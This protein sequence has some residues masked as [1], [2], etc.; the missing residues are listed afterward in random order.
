M[1][2]GKSDGLSNIRWQE[3]WLPHTHPLFSLSVTFLSWFTHSG[4]GHVTS[5]TMKRPLWQ[6]AEASCQVIWM[7]LWTDPAPWP[8]AAT[9]KETLRQNHTPPPTKSLP[10]S[11]MYEIIN[12]CHFKGLHFGVICYAKIDNILNNAFKW[13]IPLRDGEYWAGLSEDCYPALELLYTKLES[14]NRK[15]WV[16]LTWKKWVL[17]HF[18]VKYSYSYSYKNS[19]L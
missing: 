17:N 4:E 10:D 13:H 11:W 7:T 16:S 9:S 14:W 2:Y 1:K 6:G 15:K 5:S 18:I 3:D 19:M 8:L 12:I